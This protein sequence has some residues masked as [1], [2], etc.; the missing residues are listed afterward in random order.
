MFF[1]TP[2]ATGGVLSQPCLIQQHVRGQGRGRQPCL[3]RPER[4]HTC[5]P[6]AK[7]L[8]KRNNV[9]NKFPPNYNSQR[10]WVREINLE[11]RVA[12]GI[13]GFN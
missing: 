8:Y 13:D 7:S 4:Q 3:T 11:R 6:D 2:V 9:C 5:P 12:D 1:S 10:E